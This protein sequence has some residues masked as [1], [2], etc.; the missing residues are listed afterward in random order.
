MGGAANKNG[1][2]FLGFAPRELVERGRGASVIRQNPADFVRN[3]FELRPI[4]TADM[5]FYK[6]YLLPRYLNRVMQSPDFS[7][8]RAKVVSGARGIVLEI[9]FG[10]GLNLPFYKN[11]DKLYALEPSQELYN[12]SLPLVRASNFNIE[13]ILGSAEA[14]PLP[15]GSVDSVVSTWTLCSVADL[16][17]VLAEINRVLKKDGTFFFVEHGRSPKP[18]RAAIQ[19]LV[20]LVSKRCTGNCHLGRAIDVEITRAGFTI[21]E[22]HTSHEV[23]RPLMFSYQGA[24][25]S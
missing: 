17:K 5:G 6:K 2:K 14:I 3:T 7:E 13:H 18:S 23:G 9:G 25:R 8:T 21:V 12:Y 22:L 19:E 4:H 16:Q 10:S 24:A 11:V 15:D 20:T 1:R